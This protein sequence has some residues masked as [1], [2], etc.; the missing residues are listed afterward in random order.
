MRAPLSLL[1]LA[2]SAALGQGFPSAPQ[3]VYRG[4]VASGAVGSTAQ[5]RVTLWKS[6]TG[7][8]AADQLC[9][10]NISNQTTPIDSNGRFEVPLH[11]SCIEVVRTGGDVWSQLE[12]NNTPILPRT[13]L[14]AVPFATKANQANRV[15]FSG[16]AGVV[17]SDGLYCGQSPTDTTGAISSGPLIGYRAAKQICQATC[18]S[19]SAHMCSINEIIRSHEV[20]I[21]LQDGWVKSGHYVL[22]GVSNTRT[23]CDAFKVGTSTG[24]AGNYLGYGWDNGQEGVGTAPCSAMLRILCCD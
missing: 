22:P 7:T 24:P 20:R 19:P 3:L 21:P 16:D 1:V 8:L 2:S 11:D 18:N 17:T 6:S 4:A 12:V 9:G 5:M 15:I 14:K 13:A 10:T 23:D